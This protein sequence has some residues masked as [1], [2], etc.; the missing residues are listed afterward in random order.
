[1]PSASGMGPAVVLG[2]DL[3]EVAGTV[4]DACAGTRS[5]GD[6]SGETV[7]V[8]AELSGVERADRVT[9]CAGGRVCH[10]PG[11]APASPG[12]WKPQRAPGQAT[13]SLT[14]SCWPSPS[15]SP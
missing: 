4:G 6:V 10:G 13:A 3:A 8:E 14:M 15:P 7:E 1:M 11:A 5:K 9:D 2:Q 12:A